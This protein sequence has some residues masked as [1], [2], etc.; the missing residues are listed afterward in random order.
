MLSFS[1]KRRRANSLRMSRLGKLSQA[2]QRAK[3]MAAMDAETVA[4]MLANP[5][6]A[7]GDVIGSIEVSNFR[8]GEVLRWAVLR[9]DRVNN[10]RLRSPDGRMSRAHGL[11]WILDHL[12]PVLV[13]KL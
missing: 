1:Q 2:A 4:D 13:R 9:G 11:A 6:P 12:R 7:P 5:A 3:R 10:Y 8:T